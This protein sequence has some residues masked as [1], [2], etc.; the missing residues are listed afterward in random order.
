[1]NKT[2]LYA[3]AMLLVPWLSCTDHPVRNLANP[4]NGTGENARMILPPVRDTL[5]PSGRKNMYLAGQRNQPGFFIE[6]YI[7]PPGY[8][9]MPHVHNSD[10]YITII[11]GAAHIVQEKVF[12][13]MAPSMAYGPGSF[14]VI[15][16]DQP[17]FEYFTQECTMQVSGIGPNETYYLPEN[18]T[19]K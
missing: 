1:M 6:R 5:L 16:A 19:K 13:T 18:Q 15:K 2:A 7:F 3:M 10:L 8:K 14:L 4:P 9:G 17:H 12:D 11:S